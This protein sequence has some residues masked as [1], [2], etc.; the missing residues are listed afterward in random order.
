[1][2]SFLKRKRN[3]RVALSTRE[4]FGARN[5]A[6]YGLADATDTATI[7]ALHQI[8]AGPDELNLRRTA[9]SRLASMSSPA[10]LRA[11][12][13]LLAAQST[14]NSSVF[15]DAHDGLS[16]NTIALRKL[17]D[18]AVPPLSKAG[19]NVLVWKRGTAGERAIQATAL[20]QIREILE[21]LATPAAQ[22]ARAELNDLLQWKRAKEL[23]GLVKTALETGAF[24]EAES[25][26]AE[27][28][29]LGTPDALAAL[30]KIR[31][32]P[33]RTLD[34]QF[35]TDNPDVESGYSP[36]WV[37]VARP[38]SELGETLKGEARTRWE[39]AGAG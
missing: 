22:S 23:P 14:S 36:K 7:R 18:E 11:L 19:K 6:I 4:S 32:Q 3:L 21:K 28:A 12:L 35:E 17:A 38:S 26:I 9:T 31:K 30:T 33:A 24:D 1:L 20:R 25:A 2:F 29:E 34:H 15:V 37:S 13:D 39:R 5:A 8:A 16:R 10:S 27:I